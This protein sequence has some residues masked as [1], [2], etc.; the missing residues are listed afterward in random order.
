M[1]IAQLVTPSTTPDITTERPSAN[2]KAVAADSTRASPLAKCLAEK[3]VPF[4]LPGDIGFDELAEAYNVRL[5]YT[6]AVIVIP[7]HEKYVQHIQDAVLCAAQHGLKVQARGGGH[8]YASFSLGGQ[9]GSM[10]IDLQALQ[11]VTVFDG[12]TAKVGAGALL[13]NV[14]LALYNHSGRALAHGTCPSVGI[15]GHATHGGYG[16]ESRA[17]GLTLDQIIA[18]DVVLADG[19]HVHTNEKEHPEV[20][21]VSTTHLSS[22]SKWFDMY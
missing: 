7:E 17:W 1:A 12:H 20:Y 2:G 11:D 22:G 10:V 13:G 14:A 3:N 15:A 6:P 8:S 4:K 9:D 21:Y 5:Q 19:T 18:M 16:Y